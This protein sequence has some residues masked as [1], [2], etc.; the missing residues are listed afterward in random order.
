[1][2]PQERKGPNLST[3]HRSFKLSLLL[4]AV[5]LLGMGTVASAQDCNFN[6]IPDECDIDCGAPGCDPPPDCGGSEDCNANGIPDECDVAQ[7]IAEIIDGAGDSPG[8]DLGG[9]SGIAVDAA[10]IFYV[11]GTQSDNAFKI[12]P[13]GTI[14]EIIDSTG[15]GAGNGLDH[16]L[17]I[18]ADAAGNAYVA[19]ADSN[20]AFKITPSGVIT[21]IIDSTG[22]D[23]GHGLVYPSGVAVD[24][25]GNVYVTGTHGDNAFKITSEGIITQII[26]S[27]GDGE[28]NG[29]DAPNDVTADITGNV[30]VAGLANNNAFKITPEGVITQIID[31]TGDGEG[32]GLD[33]P[34]GVTADTAGN[35]Y[36]TGLYS[37]NAFKISP[38]GGITEIINSAGDSTGNGLSGPRDIAVDDSGNVLVSGYDSDNAFKITPTGV[39]TQIIDSTGDGEGNELAGPSEIAVDG[40]GNVYLSDLNGDQAFKITPAGVIT[41]I[42]DGA[43][44]PLTSPNGIA[45]DADGNVYVTGEDS[46]NAF[47]ITPAGEIT[48]IIDY[49]VLVD[50]F[51]GFALLNAPHG[52]A[53]DDAGGVYIT[54]RLS[55]NAFKIAPGGATTEIIDDSGDG[56]G[57]GLSAPKGITVDVAGNAYVVGGDSDNVFQVTPEG[58]I[59]QIIDASGDGEENEFIGPFGITVDIL[60][61]V[62]V[63]AYTS[64]NAFKITPEGAITQIIDASGDGEGRFLSSPDGIAVDDVGNVYVVG[65]SSHNAFK[66]TPAGAIT[67]IINDDVAEGLFVPRGIAVDDAGNV[68][69]TG[70][71]SDNV[72]RITPAGD[73]AQIIDVAGDGAGN[74]LRRPL[75]IAVDA[76]NSA[77]VGGYDSDNVF[78]LRFVGS[79]DCN[80]NGVPDE[81]ELVDNDCNEN[82]IPDDCEAAVGDCDDN[83]MPDECDIPIDST[84][85]GGPFFC[86]DDC[87]P[88]CNNNGTPDACDIDPFDP[89]LNGEISDDCQGDG[90][91]DECQETEDVQ[92]TWVG[93]TGLWS[94]ATNWCPD[95]V[96]DNYIPDAY[97]DV[98]IDGAAQDATLDIS[99]TIDR[100]S[101][102]NGAT[103]K[104]NDASGANVRTLAVGGII[105]N[106]GVF[107]ATDRERLVLDAPVIDQGGLWC[108]GGVLE[109]TD[110]DPS[111][112]EEE[113]KSILEINGCQ[114]LGGT[115][116]TTGDHSEIHLIG[117][118]ELVDVCIEGVVVPDGQTGQ[119]SGVISNDD[120]LKVEGKN[121]TSILMPT[122]LA[123]EDAVLDGQGVLRMTDEMNSWVGDF[124]GAFTNEAS[125]A[126]EGAGIL[127]GGITNEGT[128][129]ANVSGQELTLFPPGDKVNNG[130]L[131]ATNGGTL[132][133]DDHVTG[134]GSLLAQEGTILVYAS[135]SADP[136]GAGVLSLVAIGGIIHI[137][138]E[139]EGVSVDG[140]GPIIVLPSSAGL[141]EVIGA[142]LINASSWTVGNDQ[143]GPG[144]TATMRLID[145]AVG[146]V[147]GP[148][149]IDRNGILI[150]T[151]ASL[152]AT[153]LVL[154]SGASL[155]LTNAS[156]TLTGGVGLPDDDSTDYASLEVGGQDIGTNPVD[157]VGDPAGF[158]NDFNIPELVIGPD[159]HVSLIDHADNGNRVD[160]GYGLSEALYVDVLRFDDA[161]GRLNLDGLHLYYNTLYGSLDQIVD[162][163]LNQVTFTH[164]LLGLDTDSAHVSAFDFNCSGAVDGN[165]IAPY[166]ETQ[167]NPESSD[168]NFDGH[169]DSEDISLLVSVLLDEEPCVALV[170]V[171]DLNRDGTANGL[172]IQVFVDAMISQ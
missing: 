100:L 34:N 152:T 149:L 163:P 5:V 91:P 143:V 6:G 40:A 171:A 47:K 98:T 3:H 72:F 96:P 78:K 36:V 7:M 93:D 27:T 23:A 151:D 172:D 2:S 138:E 60:G 144:M 45:T 67:E 31:S 54:G 81:C 156:L 130:L 46:D 117:G 64:N 148:V 102:I 61:N 166:I 11:V 24:T 10:G 97:F 170:T 150:V 139:D 16:P 57:N 32:N 123:P 52:I 53:V 135:I 124:F 80:N 145:N 62:Y 120:V 35:V 157:H 168:F 20:N 99:P 19:G 88:D 118:A 58:A 37:N 15:D 71:Y 101:L 8:V 147:N 142:S 17:C 95:V 75:G 106:A 108:E 50:G 14:T 94:I 127:F 105:L 128:I 85:P 162:L 116:R 66:I 44:N 69:V 18:A 136:S 164:V 161:Q 70:Q 9:P 122:T 109:A 41:Q 65:T 115:V 74:P 30:Y 140:D 26:D 131:Q 133:I 111:S 77:Y 129:H 159:A 33:A 59:T 29:L 132:I 4:A 167:L 103:V 153:D 79:P 146:L 114:V 22:D 92:S 137:E 38:S 134:S 158:L 160:A 86:V 121:L 28:G 68:F 107:L 126:I 155:S 56:A 51:P 43:E 21:E 90:I 76:M 87:D 169:L 113:D 141:I 73:I 82:S 84:A 48:E 39:I 112:G 165:D 104:V 13:A 154:E 42:I 119:F 125:H 49:I 110:G 83:G 63:T 55:D 89:D 1:M 25:T 12:T